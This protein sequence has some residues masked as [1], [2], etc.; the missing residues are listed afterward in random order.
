GR[1]FQNIEEF[2]EECALLIDHREGFTRLRS[3]NGAPG[4][5]EETAPL[6]RRPEEARVNRISDA[7]SPVTL[8]PSISPE[9]AV[10]SGK[11]GVWT[12]ASVLMA[13]GALGIWLARPAVK[14]KAPLSTSAVSAQ[15][16]SA[17][18]S[19]STPP[20]LRPNSQL[21]TAGATMVAPQEAASQHA[22]PADSHPGGAEE[23]QK[24]S[25]PP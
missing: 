9:R 1:R 22:D 3:G 12:V 6:E 17:V 8:R 11:R 13:L 23:R 18:D 16:D 15:G 21:R 5:L 4:R 10:Y 7:H 20:T 2:T 14:T 25:V 24:P 19:S